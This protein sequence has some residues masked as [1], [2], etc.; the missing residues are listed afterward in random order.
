[1][2]ARHEI[3]LWRYFFEMTWVTRE[4]ICVC[5]TCEVQCT[6]YRILMLF[7]NFA[8]NFAPPECPWK[9]RTCCGKHTL[10]TE[11]SN[12]ILSDPCSSIFLFQSSKDQSM[13]ASNPLKWSKNKS[14]WIA[15]PGSRNMGECLINVV[16]FCEID[17]ASFDAQSIERT[18]GHCLFS[19]EM[20][21]IPGLL[22]KS[23]T[24]SVILIVAHW[25]PS[26]YMFCTRV[27]SA[28]CRD[29]PLHQ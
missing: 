13:L 29:M 3:R 11:Y 8:S 5:D 1:M 12:L 15:P 10:S 6:V 26:F 16:T 21:V 4:S 23:F 20:Y 25:S 14:Q 22:G 24:N 18:V 19:V 2:L 9:A 7:C 17:N 28:D 27:L